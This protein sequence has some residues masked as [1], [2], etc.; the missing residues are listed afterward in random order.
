MK[1]IKMRPSTVH[2]GAVACR[3]VAID[4]G[5]VARQI[6]G[7]AAPPHVPPDA[8]SQIHDA[9]N[10]LQRSAIS[11]ERQ[12]LWLLASY[13]QFL[14][15]DRPSGPWAHVHVPKLLSPWA[16]P[17]KHKSLGERI[18]DA[19]RGLLHGLEGGLDELAQTLKG[20]TDTAIGL[21]AINLDH[22]IPGASKRIPGMAKKKKQLLDGI[23]WAIHHPD[24]LAKA[25]GSDLI[26]LDLWKKGEYA[27][28][29]GHNVVG[30]AG[31]FIGFGKI[32]AAGGST[33]KAARAEK[34]VSNAA[35]I[36][37]ATVRA[38][39][40]DNAALRGAGVPVGSAA[41]NKLSMAELRAR[42]AQDRVDAAGRAKAAAHGRIDE[43]IKAVKDE[44]VEKVKELP[45]TA[46]LVA[47][48]GH[49]PD[50]P[51]NP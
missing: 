18:R 25:L 7:H 9:L 19:G 51:K 26:A 22:I 41:S 16:M 15:A 1:T 49:E 30:L 10:Q 31:I 44:L 24:E 39:A 34:A 5:A 4:A 17:G 6:K 8:L 50:Q 42:I 3:R 37:H 11:T 46:A 2:H 13:H 43:G 23:D 38:L 40:G 47:P 32:A 14:Q 12:A 27:K 29:I 48:V 20:A 35:K 45:R 36:E 28:A 21:A 33:L